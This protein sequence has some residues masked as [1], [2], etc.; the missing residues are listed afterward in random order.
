MEGAMA[1]VRSLSSMSNVF[2]KVSAIRTVGVKSCL[3]YLCK[4]SFDL[5]FSIPSVN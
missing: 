1:S 4:F 2:S 3:K 5:W